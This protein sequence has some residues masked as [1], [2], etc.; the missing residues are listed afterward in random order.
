MN[1]N[2][3]NQTKIVFLSNLIYSK[4]PEEISFDKLMKEIETISNINNR[5]ILDSFSIED[6]RFFYTIIL[7]NIQQFASINDTEKRRKIRLEAISRIY[8]QNIGKEHIQYINEII[9]NAKIRE[10]LEQNIE[11]EAFVY[12][13]NHKYTIDLKGLFI[14]NMTYII[15]K[16]IQNNYDI[17]TLNDQK[18]VINN[19]SQKENL[20]EKII[21]LMKKFFSQKI[22]LNIENII[23]QNKQFIEYISNNINAIKMPIKI[24]NTEYMDTIRMRE[25]VL[26]KREI[27]LE[28]KQKQLD[29]LIDK[30]I[31]FNNELNK[32]SSII[33]AKMENLS[34]Y[35]TDVLEL[36]HSIVK[37]CEKII[38]IAEE[39][40][41]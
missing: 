7:E 23:D 3:L 20:Q 12:I 37:S 40:K 29:T 38:K 9:F 13:Q 28:E 2:L 21:V 25:E 4:Y 19:Y 5:S 22:Q 33:N 1:H 26:N 41:E 35:K 16:N 32:K 27:E 14:E 10:E 11:S 6:L 36:F 24:D 30:N 34:V 39:V 15:S 17:I 8:D 18:F 31:A